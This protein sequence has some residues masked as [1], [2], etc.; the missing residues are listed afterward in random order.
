VCDARR[1]L[2]DIGILESMEIPAGL[3]GRIDT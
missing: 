3:P 1:L 2:D